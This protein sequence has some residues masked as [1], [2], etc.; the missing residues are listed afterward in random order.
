MKVASNICFH[1]LTCKRGETLVLTTAQRLRKET[2]ES[3]SRSEVEKPTELKP[4][5]SSKS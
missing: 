1:S 5:F 3:D 4:G 2:S